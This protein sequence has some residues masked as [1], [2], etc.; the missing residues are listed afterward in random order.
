VARQVIDEACDALAFALLQV[1][2]LLGTER[3]ILTGGLARAGEALRGPVAKR[4]DAAASFRRPTVS[5]GRLGARAGLAGALGCARKAV[6]ASR[7]A[8]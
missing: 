7:G 2:V 3:F 1:S 6:H 5:L 4:L 8:A